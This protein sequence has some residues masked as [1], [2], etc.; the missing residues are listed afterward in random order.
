MVGR[1]PEFMGHKVEAREVKIAALVTLLSA[2][3]IKVGTALA[4]YIFVHYP[5]MAWSVQPT[6]WLN[7]PGA[8]GGS[9]GFVVGLGNRSWKKMLGGSGSDVLNSVVVINENEFI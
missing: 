6:A 2:F 3:L 9:D 8:H 5:D 1:T 7:N 4:A